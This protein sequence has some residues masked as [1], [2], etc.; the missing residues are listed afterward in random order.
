MSKNAKESLNQFLNLEENLYG[1]R[2]EISPFYPGTIYDGGELGYSL[3]VAMGAVL[4]N[5]DLTAVVILGDGECETGC[6]SAAWKSI[7]CLG[8]KEDTY[9]QSLILMNIVWVEDL[10]CL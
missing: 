8:K 4:D 2:S 1:F 9:Y 3:A 10:C 5:E 6:I 7:K